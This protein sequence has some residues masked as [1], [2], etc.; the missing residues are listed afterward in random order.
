VKEDRGWWDGVDGGWGKVF[1]DVGGGGVGGQANG[2]ERGEEAE[3]G[4]G[5]GGGEGGGED[6]GALFP[7]KG[8]WQA[9]AWHK[10]MS[11]ADPSPKTESIK[12][13][14]IKAQ[15]ITSETI[16]TEAAK[17]QEWHKHVESVEKRPTEEE[18]RPNHVESVEN[19][20][21]MSLDNL[22]IVSCVNP[23]SLFSPKSIAGVY[24]CTCI[25]M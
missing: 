9:L 18:K 10:S 6:T 19:N 24:I 20:N 5:D 14:T 1:P 25:Y 2:G 7:L 17:T 11:V 12:S 13:E 8:M 3:G 21:D 16:K 22:V 15:G 23:D 4:G